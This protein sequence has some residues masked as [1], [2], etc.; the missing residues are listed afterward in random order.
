MIRLLLLLA[1]NV[2]ALLAADWLIDGIEITS[3]GYAVAAG[4]ILGVINWLVKPIVTILAIPLI[5][6]TLGIALFFVNLGML[7]LAA[8]IAPEFTIDGFWPA[9]GAT[10]VVWAVNVVLQSAFGLN[11]ARRR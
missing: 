8:W 7:V 10:I 2:A 5:V 11:G 3:F 4:A 6:L 1:V 9:V